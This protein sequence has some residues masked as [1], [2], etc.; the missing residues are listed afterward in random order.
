MTSSI[1]T[2]AVSAAAAAANNAPVA[3]DDS[4]GVTNGGTVVVDVISNDSD[5]DGDALTIGSAAQGTN[6]TVAITAGGVTYSHD[7]SD[8]TSDTFTYT[9]SDCIGGTATATVTVTVAE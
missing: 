9:L 3:V 4:G 7:G 1:T 5:P 8:S 6:G 2:T